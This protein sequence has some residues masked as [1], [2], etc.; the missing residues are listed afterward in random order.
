MFSFKDDLDL[1]ELTLTLCYLPAAGRLTVT[2]VKAINLKAMD[3]NGKSGKSMKMYMHVCAQ[4]LLGSMFIS[5]TKTK[6]SRPVRESDLSEQRQASE[7]EE[8]LGDE[9][10]SASGLQRVDALRHPVRSN[11]V[12]GHGGQGDRLRPRRL[13]RAHRLHRHRTGVQWSRPR[14]LVPHA[15]ESAQADHADLL[16]QGRVVLAR[17]LAAP[18]R[19]CAQLGALEHNEY[20]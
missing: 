12:G 10:H 2:I 18:G 19:A 3:I 5:T 15:R 11:R 9:E 17:R 13:E 1:G 14:S 4:N 7:K 8:D 6:N 16:S 20:I